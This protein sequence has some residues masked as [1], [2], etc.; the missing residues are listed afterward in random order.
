MTI[1]LGS[2]RGHAIRAP[3]RAVLVAA[4]LL[5]AVILAIA[6]TVSVRDTS[7]FVAVSRQGLQTGA[8]VLELEQTLSAMRDAE[9]GQRGFLLTGDSAY[10]APF[11]A[12][13]TSVA[14]HLAALARL[15]ANA[16]QPGRI[17]L[18]EL[19]TMQRLIEAKQRELEGTLALYASAGPAAARARVAADTGKAIMDS[20]RVLLA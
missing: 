10:L 1:E 19:L 6:V 3:V 9:T 8:V 7:R 12:G 18:A 13:S 11:R 4:F 15:T 20:L 14:G 16:D 17:Q 5:V 2:V